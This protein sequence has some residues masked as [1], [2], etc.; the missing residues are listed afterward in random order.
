M[1]E[2]VLTELHRMLGRLNGLHGA[3]QVIA[4]AMPQA[5]AQ[6][7]APNM[8]SA[9]EGVHADAL[10]TPIPDVQMQE[11]LRVMTDMAAHLEAAAAQAPQPPH[12][13]PP[14]P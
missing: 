12:P 2:Q 5:I 14:S 11:M 3:V 13:A 10:A 8:R 7:I 4:A 6:A 9:I 1:N